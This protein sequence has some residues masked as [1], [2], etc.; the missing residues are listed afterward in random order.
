MS[1]VTQGEL[2]Q[3]SGLFLICLKDSEK[4]ERLSFLTR[5]DYGLLKP[6]KNSPGNT[7]ET[8]NQTY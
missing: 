5:S 4:T 3:F 1:S 7:N 6:L 2:R 8:K